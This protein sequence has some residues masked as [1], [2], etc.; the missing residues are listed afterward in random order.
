MNTS[1]QNFNYYILYIVYI[2]FI[3]KSFIREGKRL[4]NFI[5]IKKRRYR[6]HRET[7]KTAG[8]CMGFGCNAAGVIGCRII[9]SPRERLIA[10][11][12][13]SF[14]PCNGRFPPFLAGK[15]GFL[16]NKKRFACANRRYAL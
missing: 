5:H 9:D 8:M 16:V 15:N 12:T 14:V 11:L 7:N 1:E 2:Y 6:L 3:I 10:I 13:N 4:L